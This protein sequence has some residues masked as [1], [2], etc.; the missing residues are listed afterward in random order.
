MKLK[1]K[2]SKCNYVWEYK[3]ENPFYATC[4][5]CYNKVNIK[6]SKVEEEIK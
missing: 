2:N 5:R 6:K 1:C 4:P 3:G